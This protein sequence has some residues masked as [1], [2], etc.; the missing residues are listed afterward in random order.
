MSSIAERA[1]IGFVGLGAMGLPMAR[2]LLA[3]G[4]ELAGFD[5]KPAAMDALGEAGGRRA[6]SVADAARGADVLVLMVVSGAQAQ[7]VLIEGGALDA[8]PKGATVLLMATCPPGVVEALAATVASTGRVLLD[9]PVSGGVVGA[10]AGSLTIMGSGP[11]AAFDAARPVLDRLGTK[12]FHVGEQ[13]GQ[14]AMVKT[15]NQL[16]CGVHI[17]AMA[18]AFSLAGKA[19]IEPAQLLEILS[20]SAASSWMMR[21]RGPRMLLD[22]PPVASAVD[23]FVKDLGIVLDAGRASHAALPL[24]AAAHQMF[25]A[26]SGLGHGA[27]DDSQV[28]RAYD[29]LNKA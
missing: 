19:G 15:V 27:T 20:G 24:A 18:E 1:R 3:A 7:A 10:S 13:P 11:K 26:A 25:L 6:Q 16:L 22:E 4:H 5:L 21:D 23:I 29:R 28:I 14:G 12:V 9:C 17:A 8:L 2:N